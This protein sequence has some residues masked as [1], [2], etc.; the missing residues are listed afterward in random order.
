MSLLYFVS[1]SA[2]EVDILSNYK[3]EINFNICVITIYS[4]PCNGSWHNKVNID[5]HM[6][7]LHSLPNFA[8]EVDIHKVKI[9]FKKGVITCFSYSAME[10]NL[11]KLT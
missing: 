5:S 1:N 4:I 6:N 2:M 3:V 8:T 9:N 11:T 10:V 7:L